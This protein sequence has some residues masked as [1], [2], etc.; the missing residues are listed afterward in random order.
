MSFSYLRD[1]RPL[2]TT[3]IHGVAPWHERVLVLWTEDDATRHCEGHETPA[4]AF[5][6][7][8]GQSSR[9]SAAVAEFGMDTDY[10]YRLFEG[11]WVIGEAY[12]GGRVGV[13]VREARGEMGY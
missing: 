2:E 5:E 3:R 6:R 11:G 7:I 9:H 13:V 10:G 1:L 4:A 12:D 8:T